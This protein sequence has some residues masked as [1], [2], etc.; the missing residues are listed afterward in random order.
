MLLED[1]LI[2]IGIITLKLLRVRDLIRAMRVLVWSWTQSTIMLLIT[3]HI[4][5][6]SLTL[7]II[8]RQIGIV[9]KKI[10]RALIILKRDISS[11]LCVLVNILFF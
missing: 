9:Q 7:I 4:T 1:L 2:R 10:R 8:L 6:I 3:Q 11:P 5:L